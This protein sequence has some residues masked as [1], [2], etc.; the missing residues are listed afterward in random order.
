M[1]FNLFHDHSAFVE[2]SIWHGIAN[3]EGKGTIGIT[4]ILKDENH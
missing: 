1:I 3:L 2:N 4:F